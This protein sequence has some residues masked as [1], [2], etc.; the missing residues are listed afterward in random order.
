[1]NL[2]EN[3]EVASKNKKTKLIMTIIIIMIAILVAICVGLVIMLNNIQTNMLKLTIDAKSQSKFSDKMFVI[4]DNTIYVSIEDFAPLVG[5]S[6]YRG[7]HK[8]ESDTKGYIQ[9]SFEEA[10]FEL[11]SNQI[12]KTIIGE[13]HWN[14]GKYC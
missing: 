14:F 3:E 4:E 10:S 2:L 1:M 12:T 13:H 5:Y 9:S 7:D 8:S 6:V 11:N